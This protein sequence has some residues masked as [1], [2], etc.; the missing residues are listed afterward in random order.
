MRFDPLRARERLGDRIDLVMLTNAGESQELGDEI[1]E[2]LPRDRGLRLEI[3][4]FIQRRVALYGSGG[5]VV[6]GR[7]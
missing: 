2:L 4:K 3:A 7:R 6:G 1:T 5:V